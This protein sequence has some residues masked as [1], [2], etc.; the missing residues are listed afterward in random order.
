MAVHS[1]KDNQVTWAE[2]SFKA[3]AHNIAE[4]KR[5]TGGAELIPVI[6]GNAYGHGAYELCS[7]LSSRLE[8]DNFGLARVCEGAAL[9]RAGIKGVNFII[10]GGFFKGE[11]DDIIKYDLQ[12]SVFAKEE[13]R[14]LNTAAEKAGIKTGVHLKVNTGMNRL[15][16]KPEEAPEFFKF[17]HSLKNIELKSV[18]T[19]FANADIKNDSFTKKQAE[20]FAAVKKLAP[21]GVFFHAASS[22]A[23]AR[24]PQTYFDAVRPG[25]ALYGSYGGEFLRK[26]LD[27]EPVMTLKSRVINVLK[28][29]KGESV[30]YAGL[31]RAKKKET[32]AIVGIGYG[33]GFRR[34]LS[35]SWY[36]MINGKKAPVA[37]RVCM[38]LIAVRP[39]GKVKIGDEVL[40]FGRSGRS[41]I[42]IEDMA[43]KAG[44]ISYEI[45]T[46]I[47]DRVKRIYK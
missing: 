44:T 45:F 17:I 14:A 41:E 12:P 37:G 27:L 8:I 38:D 15:G 30:S 32:I 7:F 35:N 19:H 34:S 23:I 36:V 18:Y 29:Q 26:Y 31:Y 46:G 11:I 1:K 39:N 9:R 5:K 3:L 24:Y 2:I 47:T 20:R 10:I 40:I 4:L 28:L 33:D 13:L 21:E 16:I 42:R 43:E 25:I 6:K 22:A